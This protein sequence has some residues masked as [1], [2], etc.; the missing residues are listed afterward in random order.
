[1][2]L[3]ERAVLTTQLV[4]DDKLTPGLAKAEASVGALERQ[5]GSASKGLTSA[6]S[7]LGQVAA[8]GVAGFAAFKGVE[9]IGDA[10]NAASDLSETLSKSNVVF[11]QSAQTISA[12]GDTT[13]EAL[14]LS[15]QAAVE[16]AA[17]F[18][19]LFTGMGLSQGAA[20][21]MSQDIVQ[22]A[23]DL[24]SFNNIGT[25]EALQK[26]RS[27]LVGEA[28][29]LRSVGVLLNEATVNAKAA[30]L[31]FTRVNGAFT[32]AQK[33][34]ARYA[35]ILEQT[36][37]AQG[38]FA[39][40]S[41]GLANSQRI[42]NAEIQD[43]MA[44]LGEALVPFAAQGARAIATV[45][46]AA[47]DAV[48]DLEQFVGIVGDVVTAADRIKAQNADGWRLP[49]VADA[50]DAVTTGAR[51]LR[52]NNVALLTP[53]IATSQAA[54]QQAVELD[55]VTRAHLIASEAADDYAAAQARLGAAIDTSL[56]T[57]NGWTIAAGNAGAAMTLLAGSVQ[58]TSDPLTQA[59]LDAVH[60]KEAL[61]NLPNDVFVNIR[62]K[63]IA[64]GA[65]GRNVAERGATAVDIATGAGDPTIAQHNADFI[66][67]QQQREAAAAAERERKADDARRKREQAQ[68]EAAA[69]AKRDAAELAAINREKVGNSYDVAKR[70]S[71]RLFD[72][73]HDRH[74]KAIKDAETLAEKQHDAAVQNI[75]DTLSAQKIAN[76]APVTAAEKAQS[77]AE[78]QRQRRNL[79]ESVQAARQALATNRDQTRA[80]DL[81]RSLRDATES[82]QSF[83]ANRAIDRLKAAQAI[84]DQAAENAA[85]IARDKADADLEAAKTKAA[86]DEKFVNTRDAKRKQDFDTALAAL[87]KRDE[88]D[89]AKFLT[90]LKQLQTKFGIFTDERGFT[91][92]GDVVADAI[93]TTKPPPV[94]V[95][96]TVPRGAIQ[97]NGR[98]VN[99]A[100]TVGISPTQ[101]QSAR[102]GAARPRT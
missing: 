63:T 93:K 52:E 7:G 40:T 9:I 59:T 17:S 32:E 88:Q 27:G 6:F 29:P 23:G 77:D 96:L 82:L 60:F 15:K 35:I 5:V 41:D 76:A 68:R 98:D 36:K 12:W 33:V 83:D 38:D 50:I 20:A 31:G 102:S 43:A 85:K 72:S 91:H 13:A 71:D 94:N 11:G 54:A 21:G 95:T 100:A 49:I 84:Q 45:A 37:T 79:V 78:S 47:A 51:Q 55:D 2:A 22:L 42:A 10:I 18:G 8:L 87:K 44:K 66:I 16:A 25:D 14:G 26:L 64:E 62:I 92:I 75:N 69:Q 58:E 101:A 89:P 81:Q 61:E 1:L 28:E 80:L 74:V 70:A 19:N 39:R 57:F 67:E 99:N 46:Q 65:G 90:D 97:L 86:A 56:G 48:G 53:M 4:L 24:A 73:L 30:E 3:A 34:Q